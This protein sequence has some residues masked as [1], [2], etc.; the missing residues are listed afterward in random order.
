MTELE[1]TIIPNTIEKLGAISSR[2][3]RERLIQN[4]PY[5]LSP[6]RVNYF[7]PLLSTSA[8][9]KDSLFW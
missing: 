1:D 3:H 7:L 9:N 8:I 5:E 2:I 6:Y 4:N